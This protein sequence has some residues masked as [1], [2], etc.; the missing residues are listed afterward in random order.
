MLIQGCD[1]V[2]A[3]LQLCCLLDGVKQELFILLGEI[4]IFLDM[5]ALEPYSRSATFT[6]VARLHAIANSSH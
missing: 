1:F 4:L 6:C 3:D 5:P 2:G